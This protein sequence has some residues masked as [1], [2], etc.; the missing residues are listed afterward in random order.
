MP[1]IGCEQTVYG[2]SL[3]THC[4]A[5]EDPAVVRISTSSTCHGSV[6]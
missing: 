2:P 6:D 1:G 3:N 5:L 4:S